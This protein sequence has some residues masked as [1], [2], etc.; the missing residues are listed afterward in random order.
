V[1]WNDIFQQDF[2]AF[3]R[4]SAHANGRLGEA[5]LYAL[6]SPGKRLR[7]HF[8][9]ESGTLCG[10]NPKSIQ[11]FSFSIELVHL[12]SLIHDDLPCLDNDDFRRGLPTVHKQFD[13]ATALLAG[14]ALLNLASEAF[15]E[16]RAGVEPEAFFKAY[17]YFLKAIGA[18]GMVGGQSEELQIAELEPS[19][20]SLLRIQDLKTGALFRASLL[21]PLLLKGLTSSDAL[22][23][24]I[25]TFAT[26][27][28]FAF[29]IA[30]DLEDEIQDQR[31]N[32]KNILS[33]MGRDAAKNLAREKLISLPISSQF[34]ATAFLLKKL[35]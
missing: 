29:Q 7:P 5:M 18:A 31:E 15:L 14:D 13:E 11:A 28:G 1:S 23:Q 16:A 9:Y 12:F 24:E 6:Q 22:F 3:F 21:V 8:A 25:E 35:S 2:E 26:H 34:S 10:L 17:S 33:L 19:Q 20:I 27:F 4:S 30:D 32:K